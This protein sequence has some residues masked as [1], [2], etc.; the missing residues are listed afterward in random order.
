VSGLSRLFTWGNPGEYVMH[1][2]LSHSCCGEAHRPPSRGP[3]GTVSWDLA[4]RR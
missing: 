4:A 2:S 3:I 1:E